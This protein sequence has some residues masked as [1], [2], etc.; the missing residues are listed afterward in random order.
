MTKLIR[1]YEN[2]RGKFLKEQKAIH[3]RGTEYSTELYN[4]KLKTDANV[5]KN[6]DK[7]ETEKQEK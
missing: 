6:E 7:I 2:R 4:Y 3:K 5:L 1:K